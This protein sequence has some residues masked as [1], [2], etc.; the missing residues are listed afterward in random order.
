MSGGTLTDRELRALEG[1]Y[2]AAVGGVPGLVLRVRAG[3]RTFVLRYRTRAGDQR[4]YKLGPY[5]PGRA[6][7]VSLGEAREK[8]GELRT[9]IRNG[10][11]PVGERQGSRGG[12]TVADLWA[13]Y[14]DEHARPHKK[15]SSVRMDELNWRN[16]L[17]PVLGSARIEAVSRTD[18]VELHA[19]IGRQHAQ[20]RASRRKGK[21][22]PVMRGGKGVANRV[23]ALLSKMFNCAEDWGLRPQSSNP[24]KRVKKYKEQRRERFLSAA[25][26][27]RLDTALANAEA[28][29]PGAVA[30]FRLLGLTGCR[31]GEIVGLTWG[32][33]DFDRKALRLPDS[34]T[35]AKVVHLSD[36][37]AEMLEALRHRM[38]GSTYVC[39]SETGGRLQNVQRAWI[40]IRKAASLEDVNL[41]ALR[42]TYASEAIAAGV[43]IA[44]VGELLGHKSVTTTR[45]YQ[46]LADEK[47]RE[48]ANKAA[49]AIVGGSGP[50]PTARAAKAE[51]R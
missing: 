48:A 19:K 7:H 13:R 34:K 31:L 37:A 45:R 42:H 22:K 5:A 6:D 49:L 27:R 46:H 16:H 20:A 25:E 9:Q 8:A 24:C 40:A 28:R 4:S 12:A 50:Q 39:P 35:G 2:E 1:P 33:V 51:T 32:M 23:L 36:P 17:A 21:R 15:P 41:H 18:V 14:L 29:S 11:D 44:I 47:L 3:T 38:T 30:C 10:R 43:P 26:R